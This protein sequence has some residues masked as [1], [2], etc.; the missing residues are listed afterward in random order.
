MLQLF[1]IDDISWDMHYENFERFRELMFK[2]K[3]RPLL[4]V[5]P[6][7]D[8][9]KLKMQIGEKC[10]DQESFWH[11]IRSLQQNHGW[12]IAMHGYNH[13]YTTNDSGIFKINKRAEFAGLPLIDQEEK[14]HKGKSVFD[15]KGIQI[16]AFMAPAHSLDWNTI[17]ALKENGIF[18]ITDGRCAYPYKKREV[19]FV[20]QV[21][22]WP[23]RKMLGI[24]TACF[25]INSWTES[26]FVALE[27]YIR[28]NISI[29]GSFG[30]VAIYA[31][32]KIPAMWKFVNFY[33]SFFF[34]LRIKACG[35]ASKTK[36]NLIKWVKL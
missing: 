25:H 9:A 19:L 13:V 20:P 35:M 32:K 15:Q 28:D 3:I 33:T 10:I 12:A 31:Q 34:P 24:Y 22:S 30:D 29:C 23:R 21:W 7:N 2:Y 18:I 17:K 6:A 26:N 1:R 5:I 16:D 8:D 27:K 4:G 14:I 36:K 11:E